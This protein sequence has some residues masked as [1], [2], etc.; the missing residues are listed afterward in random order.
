MSGVGR[1]GLTEVCLHL[2]HV[3]LPAPDIM[4]A[5]VHAG[6]GATTWCLLPVCGRTAY[7]SILGRKDVLVHANY[8]QTVRSL[9]LSL[10]PSLLSYTLT[11][12]L[13]RV[14]GVMM[15]S[16]EFKTSRSIL[17]LIL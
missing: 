7:L 17:V 14:R 1:S 6:S 3:H 5:E 15:R 12:S 9:Y 4:L 10:F 2:L 13:S 16:K 8:R 11:P